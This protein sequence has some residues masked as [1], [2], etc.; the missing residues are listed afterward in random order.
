MTL[1]AKND[2]FSRGLDRDIFIE[3]LYSFVS[4]NFNLC[5]V[6]R[7]RC[8]MIRLLNILNF[9]GSHYDMYIHSTSLL[10]LLIIDHTRQNRSFS[11][12]CW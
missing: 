6:L 3:Q 9:M 4:T 12:T 5:D 10:V 11:T 8:M 2:F 7:R 1:D